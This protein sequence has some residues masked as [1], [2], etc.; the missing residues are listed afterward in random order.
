MIDYKVI[1]V[2][3][4]ISEDRFVTLL[5][6]SP[7]L[8]SAVQVYR[9]CVSRRVSPLFLAAMF[10]KESTQGRYG[11]ATRT[12]SWGNTRPPSFGVYGIGAYNQDTG[13]FYSLGSLLP[14]GRYLS[15]YGNWTEGGISTVARL[16]EHTPYAGRKSVREIIPIWA[17]ATDQNDPEGYIQTVLWYIRENIGAGFPNAVQPDGR[18][19]IGPVDFGGNVITVAE[20]IVRTV[21]DAGVLHERSWRLDGLQ[22][23]G[24]R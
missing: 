14:K 17:P 1:D 22:P 13:R 5:Q 23:W 20:V 4:D 11:W 10:Y 15:A 7:A 6:G 3:P 19:Q 2:N 12:F 24:Y 21:N 8:P 9:Y 16:V 18:V